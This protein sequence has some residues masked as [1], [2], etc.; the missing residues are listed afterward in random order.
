MNRALED[1]EV[2]W[3]ARARRRR[4]I[5]KYGREGLSQIHNYACMAMNRRRNMTW[6]QAWEWAEHTY[7][8]GPLH[9][10]GRS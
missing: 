7:T 6:D 8:N 5:K 1:L 2:E 9:E 3:K 10:T 4:L